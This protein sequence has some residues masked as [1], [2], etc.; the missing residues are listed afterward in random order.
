MSRRA[1]AVALGFVLLFVFRLIASLEL[2]LGDAEALYFCYG[3]HPSLSYLDHPPLVGWLNAAVTDLFG[4]TVLSVRLVA[5]T[6]TGLTALVAYLFTRDLAGHRAGLATL[7]LLLGTPVFTVGM[8]ATTPDAPLSV[9]WLLFT[10]QLHRGLTDNKNGLWSLY[11][12][13]LL[14]GILLGAAFLAKYTGACLVL[15]ALIVLARGRGRIWLSRPSLYFAALLAFA[16]TFPVLFWNW[17][18]DFVG[19]YHRLVWT[20]QSAGFSPRNFGALIGGQLLYMGPLMVPLLF[21]AGYRMWVGRRREPLRLILIAASLPGLLL[22]FL[23]VLWSDV[24]E[25]HWPGVAY[26][27]L[28]VAAGIV[29][30]E[31]GEKVRKL[32][33][34][35]VAYGG[36][37]FLVTN[38]LVLTPLWP[39]LGGED[40]T[41]H[42]DLGNELRGW[43]ELRDSL[44]ELNRE[45]RPIVAAFYTI[46]SQLTF[47]M[48]GEKD[49]EVRC[50][51]PELDDFDIWY[52]EFSLPPE[53]ALFVTD[54]RFEHDPQT[55]L[56]NVTVTLPPVTIEIVR[57]R[58]WVRRF[59]IYQIAPGDRSSPDAGGYGR[60]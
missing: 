39:R 55:V 40:Y 25:P 52:P 54:N 14:L 22:T 60:D 20:Q 34:L 41:P 57:G 43:P 47:S 17:E 27:P 4:P 26:L 28:F 36:L 42:Y 11:G 12:R 51:S 49:P 18:H 5:F 15:T 53:G 19:V 13:P 8:A 24:A 3:L 9:L 38:L 30:D 45:R 48:S 23:L 58:R 29:V 32:F 7:L 56:E 37:V 2:G 16:V 33:R 59:R 6:T 10:W 50:V 31:G 46:C 35:A 21:Y 44:R 1:L